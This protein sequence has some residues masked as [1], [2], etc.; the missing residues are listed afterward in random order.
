[1]RPY[2]L[3]ETNF[4]EVKDHSFE[5]AILPW[6]ATEA[7]NYHLPFGTDTFETEAIASE[8]AALSWSK[9]SRCLVLPAIPYGVNT[10]QADIPGTINVYPSTQALVLHDILESLQGMKIRR[11]LVLNGHGGN[12]F[13]Q[14]LREMGSKF[15]E[16]LLVTANWYQ[17]LHKKEFFTYDG[18][19]ADEME[20]SLMLHLRTDLVL[21]L[22]KA[23]EGKH[24]KF[25][26]AELNTSWAWSERKWSAVTGDTG[27]GNPKRATAAKGKIYFEAVAEKVAK[28]SME[29]IDLDPRDRFE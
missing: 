8:A 2:L 26:S 23:G 22:D 12:D 7:H 25:R 21:P 20:T 1:M 24:K 9:G 5:L 19:H 27:I 3:A 28:L 17:S 14:I 6:G 13:K 15:P 18:D 4:S 11:V 16:M 29:I 10:G